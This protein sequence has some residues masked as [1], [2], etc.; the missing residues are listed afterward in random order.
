MTEGG[1]EGNSVE[2]HSQ[3]EHVLGTVWKLD[4]LRKKISE[5]NYYYPEERT[6]SGAGVE[7]N[8]TPRE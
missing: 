2:T 8:T 3:K 5:S 7:R 6:E 4:G 1:L